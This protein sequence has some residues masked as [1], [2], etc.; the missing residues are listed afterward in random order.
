VPIEIDEALTIEVLC[1]ARL[2][3]RTVDHDR[4]DIARAIER[5]IELLARPEV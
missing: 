5:L 3:D 2:L 1:A 4:A